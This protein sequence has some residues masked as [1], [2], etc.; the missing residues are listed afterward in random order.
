MSI[1]FTRSIATN[2]AAADQAR[3]TDLTFNQPLQKLAFPKTPNPS[4][5]KFDVLPVN[6]NLAYGRASVHRLQTAQ[7]VCPQGTFGKPCPICEAIRNRP[8]DDKQF[9]VENHATEKAFL[10]VVPLDA[11]GHPMRMSAEDPSPVYYF[12]V[13]SSPK[14]NSGFWKLLTAALSSPDASDHYKK[15]FADWSQGLTLKLNLTPAEHKGSPFMDVAGIEFIPRKSQYVKEQWAPL[16]S[17]FHDLFNCME[18]EAIKEMCPH[19]FSVNTGYSPLPTAN[20][21]RPDGIYPPG[22]YSAT[23]VPQSP[24]QGG[25]Y[26]PGQQVQYSAPPQNPPYVAQAQAA[27]PAL[28]QAQLSQQLPTGPQTPATGIF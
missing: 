18:Y 25:F 11:E 7:I 9:W 2:Q 1:D 13:G 12:V 17:Q 23:Q 28:S 26:P 10:N 24:Q 19:L 8:R 3:F 22:Q 21:T 27:P 16:C 5:F 15:M 6:D 20:S 14:A 4:I